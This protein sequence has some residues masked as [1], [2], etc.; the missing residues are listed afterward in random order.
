MLPPLQGHNDSVNSVAFSP[1]GS[2][3][4]SGSDDMTIRVWNASTGIEMLPPLQGHN[5]WINSVAFSPDESRIISGSDDKTI[6]VWDASTGIEML[7]PLQCQNGSI[8]SVAFS[9]DGSKVISKSRDTTI[10]VWDAHTGLEILLE[11]SGSTP[12]PDHEM[13]PPSIRLV[14]LQRE[15]FMD[16]TTGHCLGKL[17]VGTSHDY[18][19]VHGSCYVGCTVDHKLVIIQFPE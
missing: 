10:Q 18:P 14:S 7:P 9:L 11:S 19:T 5:G 1:D 8:Y 13:S 6:R 3:I 2:K 15:W 4:I 12:Q 17:P 16:L